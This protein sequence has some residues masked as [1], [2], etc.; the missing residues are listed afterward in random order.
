MRR[1][2]TESFAPLDA[3]A[4]SWNG[5]NGYAEASD[6]PMLRLHQVWQDSCDEGFTVVSQ[7]TGEHQT[8]VKFGETRDS[9]GELQATVF[10]SLNNKTG[11]TDKPAGRLTI[12]I[13]ND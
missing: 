9:E 4:F 6:L 10:V 1:E 2:F 12:T 8:F 5:G 11:R 3:A 7:K 13:F